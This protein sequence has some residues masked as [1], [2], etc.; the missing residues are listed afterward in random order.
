MYFA[1][2]NKELF[3]L[4]INIYNFNTGVL[5]MKNIPLLGFHC[6]WDGIEDTVA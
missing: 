1:D 2:Q 4:I 6:Q 3:F 5:S